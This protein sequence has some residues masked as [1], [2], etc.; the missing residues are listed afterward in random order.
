[1]RRVDRKSERGVSLLF[2]MLALLLL[3]AIAAG[4][5]FMSST[6]T[7]IS[8]NFKAEET[9]YFASGA[10][11]EEVRDRMLKTNA[12][13]INCSTQVAEC[14]LLSTAL[15]SAAGSVLDGLQKGAIGAE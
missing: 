2:S 11:V 14:G 15:P 4:M 6:E 7:S 1:M 3:T 12:T 10:G 13:T 9:A 5:M 8:S